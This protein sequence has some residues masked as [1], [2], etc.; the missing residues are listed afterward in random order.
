M[1]L[2]SAAVVLVSVALIAAGTMFGVRTVVLRE[3]EA[4]AIDQALVNA[5]LVAGT[6]SA[7]DVDETAI[8]AALRP[9]VRS[10]P[11]LLDAGQWYSAS[12][13]FRSD[14][15]PAALVGMVVGGQAAAQIAPTSSGVVLIVGVPIGGTDAAYFEV[16]PLAALE[17]SLETVA[18]TLAVVGVAGTLAGAVLG[19][20]VSRRV[21]RPV[22]EVTRTAERIAAGAM[23]ARLDPTLDPDLARLAVSFNRMA[24]GLA[25][26]IAKEA[27]FAGDVSHEL[28]SPLTSL[29]TAISVLEG[30]RHE[31]SPQGQEALDL[32]AD[33]AARFQKTVMDLL[34][35]NRHDAGVAPTELVSMPIAE[36]V[37][38]VAGRLDLQ[39]EVG[40]SAVGAVV[41]VDLRRLERIVGNLVENALTHGGGIGRVAVTAAGPLAR[42]V[43]EDH[44][45]GVDPSDRERIFERFAR[46]GQARRRGSKTGSGLGLALAMENART[47][48]GTIRLDPTYTEGARFVFEIPLEAG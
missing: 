23:D 14:D 6:L 8:L 34:E 5:R 21:L 1:T 18:S 28:R 2:A 27:R 19:R 35:I 41:E 43:V 47:L 31:L 44:G 40:P 38:I 29:S 37:R 4:G 9:P 24:D 33:D 36:A 32:L 16:F 15:I 42:V 22:R 13:Q 17:S 46:G 11:L 25:D 48:G 39:V 3:F 30:R 26:R 20:W 12:L 7:P 10:R 45:P